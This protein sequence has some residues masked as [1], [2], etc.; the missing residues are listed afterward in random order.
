MNTGTACLATLSLLA[1]ACGTTQPP[2]APGGFVRV[3][4]VVYPAPAA[5][6]AAAWYAQLLGEAP[7]KSLLGDTGFAIGD[8]L[9]AFDSEQRAPLAVWQVVDI[10]SAFG[11]LIALGAQPVTGIQEIGDARIV[12]VRDPFGNLVGLTDGGALQQH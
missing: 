10:D 11:R 8:A 7:V 2:P 5:R 6:D 3:K 9:L 4:A 1:T 12:I